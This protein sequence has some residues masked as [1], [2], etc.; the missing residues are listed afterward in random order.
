MKAVVTESGFRNV[1]E[2]FCIEGTLKAFESTGNGHIN[3]TFLA[4]TEAGEKYIVQRI[5]HQIFKNPVKLMDNISRVCEH[6]REKVV[7]AGGDANREVLTV[8][9]TKG[10]KAYVLDEEGYYWR[11]YIFIEDTVSYDVVP[12]NEV[13]YNCAKAFGV[14]QK[15]LSDFDASTLDETIPNFHHTPK[16]YENFIKAVEKDAVNR[17]QCVE[18][19][20]AFIKDRQK[21]TE[22]LI[23]L[24][25]AGKIPLRVTHNDTKINNIMVDNT[26]QEGVCV[27][28]LDTVMPGFSAYDFGDC[29]RTGANSGEEDEIDLTKINFMTERFK[30]FAE[31][32]L[33]VVGDDFGKEEI[34]SLLIG[35]KVIILECGMRFMTDYLEGDTYFKIHREHHNLDRARTQFKLVKDME[36]QW[37]TLEAIIKQFI[38]E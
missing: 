31:G 33:S 2:Q 27:I 5:N 22:A 1:F 17:V 29:I 20:I 28:D 9:K 23:K 13:F 10:Q 38:K 12:S 6:V 36:E 11:A 21:D 25:E 4:Y 34:E 37:E 7:A 30:V 35:S 15:Y 32:F 18:E 16:R 14:F 19:E 8:I 3:D 24:Y 26:T